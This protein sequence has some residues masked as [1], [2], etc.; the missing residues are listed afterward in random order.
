MIK[1]SKENFQPEFLQLG[2]QRMRRQRDSPH[3][4]SWALED[5][6]PGQVLWHEVQAGPQSPLPLHKPIESLL[7][8][9]ASPL[10]AVPKGSPYVVG[11]GLPV[12]KAVPSQ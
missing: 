12:S 5:M 3:P 7:T 4:A 1:A 2:P 9:L 8:P 10:L 11:Q 6:H